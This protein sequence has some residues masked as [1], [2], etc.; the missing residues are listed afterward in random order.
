VKKIFYSKIPVC[1]FGSFENFRKVKKGVWDFVNLQKFPGRG[2]NDAIK[3]LLKTKFFI[4]N[5]SKDC[6]YLAYGGSFFHKKTNQ[7]TFFSVFSWPS[8]AFSTKIRSVFC[9]PPP[10]IRVYEN[11]ISKNKNQKMK[12]FSYRQRLDPP[13]LEYQNKGFRVTF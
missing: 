5:S 1:T 4:F 7:N 6:C 2:E 13:F 10:L 8:T 3:I 9:K 11:K 12:L